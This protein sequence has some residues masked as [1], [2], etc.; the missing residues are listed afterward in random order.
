MTNDRNLSAEQVIGEANE[1]CNQENLIQQLKSGV[2]ALHAPVNTHNANWAYMVMASLAWTLK[3]WFAL[4]IPVVP[5]W[6]AEHQQQRERIW[7]MDF[8]TFLHAIV[9]VPAEIV[10]SGRRLIFRIL[11]WRPDLSALFRLLDAL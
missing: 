8:R 4:M 6:R 10:R 11:A 7:R 2:R 1:R 3:A 9:L 5:R